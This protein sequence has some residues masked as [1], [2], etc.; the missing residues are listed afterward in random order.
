MKKIC[1]SKDT[2]YEC[3]TVWYTMRK[4]WCEKKNPDSEYIE[5]QA[6]LEINKKKRQRDHGENGQRPKRNFTE[7]IHK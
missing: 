5:I 6:L 1:F 2:V 7:Q 4:R 3:E